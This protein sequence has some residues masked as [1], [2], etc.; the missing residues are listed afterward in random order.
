MENNGLKQGNFDDFFA[1]AG[2]SGKVPLF[3]GLSGDIFRRG[4]GPK[5]A[6][7]PRGLDLH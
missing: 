5:Q 7:R 3:F 6:F 1:G 4:A 2:A